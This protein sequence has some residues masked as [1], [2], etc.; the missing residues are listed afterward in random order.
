MLRPQQLHVD[1]RAPGDTMTVFHPPADITPVER[2]IRWFFSVPQWV[3]LVGAA[4]AIGI[5]IVSLFALW[6]NAGAIAEWVRTRHLTT[7]MVWKTAFG[8]LGIAVLAG[9]GTSGTTFFVYSQN[10]N[11]FCLSCHSL[12]D[13]V[14]ERFQQSKHHRVANLRCHDCHDEPLVAEMTQVAKWMLL[15][16]CRAP[17]ARAVT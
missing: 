6:R 2:V 13:E 3:Q 16:P 8:L 11:Q 10:N 7:P 1:V 12:H 14:Y 4:L 5:A 9:M 17:Y 15:R